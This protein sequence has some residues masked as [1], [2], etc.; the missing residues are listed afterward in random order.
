M[1]RRDVDVLGRQV[2]LLL[3]RDDQVRVRL[4]VPRLRLH[5][6]AVDVRALLLRARQ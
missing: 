4:D 3:A 6:L 1:V 5:R 2:Q